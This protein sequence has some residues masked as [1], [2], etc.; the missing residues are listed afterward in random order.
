M[1]TAE[2]AIDKHSKLA[3]NKNKESMELMPILEKCRLHLE[4]LKML[5]TL[6]LTKEEMDIIKAYQ[7]LTIKPMIFAANVSEDD[8]AIGNHFVEK[9]IQYAAEMGSEVVIVSA[10][11][12]ASFFLVI[13]APSN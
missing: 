4:E 13:L 7:F 9:V 2:K 12:E 3:K 8:L 5:K 11:V 6:V 1:E 10:K